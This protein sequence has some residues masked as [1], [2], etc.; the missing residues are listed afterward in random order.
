MLYRRILATLILTTLTD[1]LA[2]RLLEPKR[3]TRGAVGR[4]SPRPSTA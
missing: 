2:E 1:S 3:G 4:R